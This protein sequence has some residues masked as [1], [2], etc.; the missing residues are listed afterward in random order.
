MP[1]GHKVELVVDPG[2]GV[3]LVVNGSGRA[4]VRASCVSD[5]LVLEETALQPGEGQ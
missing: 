5:A 3:L 4:M 2:P 1:P